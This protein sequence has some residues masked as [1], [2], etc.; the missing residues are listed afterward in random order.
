M[1]KLDRKDNENRQG[2]SLSSFDEKKGAKIAFNAQKRLKGKYKVINVQSRNGDNI[3]ANPVSRSDNSKDISTENTKSVKNTANRFAENMQLYRKMGNK[4]HDTEHQPE[5]TVQESEGTISPEMALRMKHAEY[6]A[7]KNEEALRLSRATVIDIEEKQ[8]TA[9][10]EQLEYSEEQENV[11][12]EHLEEKPE[13]P[14]GSS[15]LGNSEHAVFDTYNGDVRAYKVKNAYEKY[16][17]KQKNSRLD[18]FAKTAQM[19]GEISRGDVGEVITDTVI[20]SVTGERTQNAINGVETVSQAVSGSDSVGG[21]VLDVSATL[22]AVE[23]KKMVKKL[24]ETDFKKKQRVDE[25]MKNHGNRFGIDK[26]DEVTGKN[27]KSKDTKENADRHFETADKKQGSAKVG[28][29]N[30]LRKEKQEYAKVQRAKEIRGRQKEIFIK[31]NQKIPDSVYASDIGKGAVKRYVVKKGVSL[32]FGGGL[33]AVILP[34]LLVIILFV[35]L[36]GFFGWLSPFKY[37]LAGETPDTEHNAETKA[38]VIDGYTLMIK[39]YMDVTQAYYYLKYGDWY[40]GTYQ[41]ESLDLDF[42]AF[43]SDYCQNIVLEIRSQYQSLID[44]ASTPAQAMAISWAMGDAIN[45]ALSN[46]QQGALEE[47]E[48]LTTSLDDCLTPDEHRQHYEV[49]IVNSGNGT[50]DSADFNNKPIPGTNFF[51]NVEINSEL[52]AEEML[53]YIALYKSLLTINSDETEADSDFD[54][55]EKTLNITTRDI[56][57]FFEETEFISIT[58]EVTHDNLCPNQNCKRRLVGDAAN[59]YSWEYYCDGDHDNLT[60]EIGACLTADELLEKIMELTEAEEIGV[61]EDACKE[62]IEEYLD[63]FKKELDIDEGD[64]RKFGA[65]DNEKAKEFYELLITGELEN[66]DLWEVETPITEA[67]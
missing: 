15:Y 45:R 27:E 54:D 58:A 47:Y 50:D 3:S 43:F 41:Y 64:F 53:A 46:A 28:S 63:M 5:N 57:D 61:D 32:I 23:A 18:Y 6:L 16:I 12:P 42:G 55:E 20:G 19:V 9:H 51:G 49:E 24:A 65:A 2:D 10:F 59:G 36:S 52:S 34:I 26:Y 22:A 17:Q 39:N 37:G 11:P 62:L 21:A 38:E 66:A 29:S 67:E 48:Q 8:D 14:Q 31:E 13:K 30:K 44:N 25:R 4:S 60:G 1:A 35:V 7:Q 56:M 33:G 40:G